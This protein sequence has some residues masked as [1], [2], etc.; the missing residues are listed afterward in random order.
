MS[1]SFVLLCVCAVAQNEKSTKSVTDEEYGVIVNPDYVALS[2]SGSNVVTVFTKAGYKNPVL[3]YR[4]VSYELNEDK[5][6]GDSFTATIR[7]KTSSSLQIVI[8]ANSN[9]PGIDSDIIYIKAVM[10][11]SDYR[12]N[13]KSVQLQGFPLIITVYNHTK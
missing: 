12:M 13:A 4:D 11:A 1:I 7:N 10:N 3:I 9:V 2:P 6:Y 5:I 8:E